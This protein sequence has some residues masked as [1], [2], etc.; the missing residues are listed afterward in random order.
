MGAQMLTHNAQPLREDPVEIYC[1]NLGI[2]REEL[3]VG[4]RWFLEL[5]LWEADRVPAPSR[6]EIKQR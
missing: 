5:A 1:R 2:C 6:A 3:R 4:Q